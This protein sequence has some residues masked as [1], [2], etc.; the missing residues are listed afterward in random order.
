MRRFYMVEILTHSGD[1][2]ARHKCYDLPIRL[3][4]SYHNDII[5][6]DPH[7]AAEHALIELNAQGKLSLRDLGS[8][9]GLK[10]KGKIHAHPELDDDT[11]V[12]LGRTLVRVRDSDYTVAAEAPYTTHN[13][14]RSWLMF[15]CSIAIICALALS[16]AWL[17]DIANNKLS[18]YI[19]V[20]IKWLMSAAAWAGVWALANRI[21]SGN[22]N[23][24]K[25]LFILSCAML[26]LD[27]LGYAY[28]L[29]GFSLSLEYFAH[30]QNHMQLVL[31]ATTIYF[32]LRLINNRRRLLK[33]ICAALAVLSSGL[34]LMNNYQKTNQYA[35]SLY[36]SE[37]LPPALRLSRNHSLAE[38]DQAIAQLKA[39]IDA[40]R[41]QVLKEKAQKDNI[42]KP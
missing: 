19:M 28:A 41:D 11:Q 16:N 1:V 10:I 37:L 20:T 40:E 27:F 2:Q 14:A 22:A 32:H 42:N 5:L 38:F 6:D 9:N 21:F 3:G 4:R 8:K 24:G 15:A 29:L 34:L 23:F 18:D 7:T 33:L 35:D 39:D 12:Q 13:Y 17:G 25:H 26:A 30:Y 36:M 31:V